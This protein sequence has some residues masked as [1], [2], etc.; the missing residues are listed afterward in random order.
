MN[1]KNL[2]ISIATVRARLKEFADGGAVAESTKGTGIHCGF[3][4]DGKSA[5][6]IVHQNKGGGVT[7][8]PS[9]K[10]TE[11]A[12]QAAEHIAADAPPPYAQFNVSLRGYT[13]E[14]FDQLL[15][16]LR[17]ECG[18]VDEGE[19]RELADKT[20]QKL[21]G[22]NR[23]I[24]TFSLHAN[25]T[26]L[27]QGRPIAL[28]FELVQYLAEDETTTPADMVRHLGDILPTDPGGTG[29]EDQLR[30]EYPHALD[31]AGAN[32]KK[33]LC[34]A[35]AMRGVDLPT[36][37]D[38]S[39]VSMPALRAMEH[40]MKKIV[41]E[42]SGERL[43]EFIIFD[44]PTRTQSSHSV[45]DGWRKRINCPTACRALEVCYAHFVAQRHGT[46]HADGLDGG[47]RIIERKTEAV[48]IT[49]Q[50][51]TL[52]ETHCKALAEK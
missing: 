50:T 49:N 6:L 28:A 45:A 20:I 11:L 24:L 31:F 47:I 19:Q 18:A 4:K 40:F 29:I 2:P 10:E 25:G 7:L 48:A 14:S 34:T 46:F 44:R 38:Y 35:L 27:I 52:I 39:V 23:D 43:T 32:M 8:Q 17:T 37:S 13:K 5:L 1:L 16:Y 12:T 30:Q 41:L 22:P 42:R 33:L 36:G 3:V 9:G 51:M 26:L 15:L 21:K